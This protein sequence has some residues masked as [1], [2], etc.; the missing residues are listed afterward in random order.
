MFRF[1]L[2]EILKALSFGVAFLA[3]T[4]VIQA[5]GKGKTKFIA[6]GFSVFLFSVATFFW[7]PSVH[8]GSSNWWERTPWKQIVIYILMMAGI[9]CSILN[10]AILDRKKKR[11]K[12]REKESAE[13]IP[14]EIDRWDFIRPL[15]VSWCT[16]SFLYSQIGEGIL[17]FANIVLII[18]TGFCAETVVGKRQLP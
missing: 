10:K 17:D 9:W 14:L 5:T 6:L 16:Y 2:P 3:L 15:L 12:P 13:G 18:Q 11:R 4:Y 7:Y 8:L 1:S